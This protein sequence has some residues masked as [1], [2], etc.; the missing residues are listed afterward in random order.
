M[1]SYVY[2]S[3]IVFFIITLVMI[4]IMVWMILLKLKSAYLAR[5]LIFFFLSTESW[6]LLP[7]PLLTS[8][9]HGTK[10]CLILCVTGVQPVF[11][12]CSTYLIRHL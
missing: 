7:F 4:V 10:I 12:L 5:I 1:Y 11:N 9:G 6:N 3:K 8:Y 2:S